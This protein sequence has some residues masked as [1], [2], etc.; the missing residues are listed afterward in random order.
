MTRYTLFPK[1]LASLSVD[2]LADFLG[3]V[4]LNACNAVI[5]DGFWTP[6]GRLA[7]T[8]P[9]FVA[10]LRERGIE[11]PMAETDWGPR[12]ALGDPDFPESL[13]VI[14]E[15]GIRQVRLRQAN[16]GAKFGDVG[17]VPRELEEAAEAF[18][19]LAAIAA[20]RDMQLVYQ[21]HFKTLLPSPSSLYPLAKDLDPKRFG[22]MLDAGNQLME[23][24]ENW[25]RSCRLFRS[26][27][28]A[29]G[30]K[31]AAYRREQAEP[32]DPRK[33]WS[34]RFAPC[35]EGMTNWQDVGSALRD[36]NFDG[37]Y[38]LMPFYPESKDPET[39]G[40]ILKREIEYLRQYLP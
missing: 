24:W 37:L 1:P 38:V 31:D 16:S 30:V 3:D 40:P 8:L 7:E 19:K 36:V 25:L 15:A 27:L 20:D 21:T 12:E 34:A 35:D 18:R 11:T 14:R 4:G 9:R 2:E 6:P 26:Q 13:D 39:L 33:G 29:F 17:D 10:S 22:V 32:A 23:G 5:R 28:A